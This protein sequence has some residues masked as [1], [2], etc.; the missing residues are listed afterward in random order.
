MTDYID[1][2]RLVAADPAKKSEIGVKL[3]QA[4]AGFYAEHGKRLA[5]I[6]LSTIL[7]IVLSPV[8][9]LLFV[10]ISLDGARPI[11]T[12]RRA[13]RAAKQ[14][15]CLKFRSMVPN[16]E[17]LLNDVLDADPKARQEWLRFQKLEND[18][19]VTRIGRFLRATSLDELPQLWNVIKGDMSLVGPRPVTAEELLRYGPSARQVFST[20]PGMTGLWQVSGRGKGVSYADR[21]NMDVSYVTKMSLLADLSI[22]IKTAGVVFGRTGT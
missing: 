22:L 13:G 14:F 10:L 7:L 11:Y 1:P 6:V 18:P 19:R 20:R 8:F 9:L 12:Q 2:V 15:Q 5:D 17:A 3:V 4:R 16:A 21:V